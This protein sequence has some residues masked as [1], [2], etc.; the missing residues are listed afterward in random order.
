MLTG[1]LEAPILAWTDRVKAQRQHIV[2]AGVA[3]MALSVALTSFVHGPV[4]LAL[5]AAVYGPLSGVALGTAEAMVVDGA[6]DDAPRRLARWSLFAAIGDVLAPALLALAAWGGVPWRTSF[7]VAA[8]A[9]AVVALGVLRAPAPAA[10]GGD[11]EEEEDD[12][13]LW[14]SLRAALSH[15]RLAVWL[16]GAALCTLLD[17]LLAVFAA[18]WTSARFSPSLA[19]PMLIAF[20]AGM[21]LGSAL[22]E[23]ALARHRPLRLLAGSAALCAVAYVAWLLAPS[24]PLSVALFVVVGAATAPLH[25]LAKAEAFAALPDRPGL[26]NGASNAFAL[27][28]VVAPALLGLVAERLGLRAAL[29]LLVAQP[30][31]MLALALVALAPARRGQ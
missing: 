27:V 10:D 12:E 16:L 15:R 29:A 9:L 6:G 24:G 22:L 23:R 20:S 17:E 26:V 8:V 14:R 18:L 21:T 4:A 5:A 2:A 3:G 25:A 30:L 19:A 7:R 28:D 31:A 13:P 11:H 1:F